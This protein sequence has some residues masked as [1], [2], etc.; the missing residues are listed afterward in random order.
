M[1]GGSMAEKLIVDI[2]M[3][4]RGSSVT[5]NV[6]AVIKKNILQW[7]LTPGQRLSEKEISEYLEVSRTPVRE[8]F[9]RLNS[10]SLLEIL[11]QRG[12]FISKI[13]LSDVEEGLFIRRSLEISVASLAVEVLK[14]DSIRALKENLYNL[15]TANINRDPVE[16]H[17]YDEEFHKSIFLACGKE[18]TWNVMQ[19]A[20]TQYNRLRMLTLIDIDKFDSIHIEHE[21]IVKA[22]SSGN[23]A[24]VIKA[25]NEHLEH[26]Y[27]EEEVLKKKYPDYFI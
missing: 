23:A 24:D 4:S 16:F 26:L 8:S 18:K 20:N 2:P 21:N 27:I 1:V 14:E 5:D 17:M 10:E 9:I 6:Y 22:I 19:G 11:P 13:D 7:K 12:S 3:N 15:N 25:V